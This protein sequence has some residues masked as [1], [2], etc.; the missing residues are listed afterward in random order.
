MLML[1][2]LKGRLHYRKKQ[3]EG[4]T[5]LDWWIHHFVNSILGLSAFFIITAYYLCIVYLI[6]DS[7]LVL[8]LT[9]ACYLLSFIGV[10][11]SLLSMVKTK[12][13]NVVFIKKLKTLKG[14]N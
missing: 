12:Y 11:W 5:T 3:L 6:F 13:R 2:L 1:E 14:Q 9:I 7:L 4:I 8:I 10:C